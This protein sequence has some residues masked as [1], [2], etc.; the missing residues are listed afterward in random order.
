MKMKK[1]LRNFAKVMRLMTM[2][3]FLGMS[4]INMVYSGIVLNPKTNIDDVVHFYDPDC[5]FPAIEKINQS[6][7]IYY[8]SPTIIA[9]LV[10]G[11]YNHK[12]VFTLTIKGNLPDSDEYNIRPFVRINCGEEIIYN[13]ELSCSN[14]SSDMTNTTMLSCE[15]D[16]RVPENATVC[17]AY[18]R[19]FGNNRTWRDETNCY[20]RNSSCRCRIPNLSRVYSSPEREPLTFEEYINKC[21]LEISRRQTEMMREQTDISKRQAEIMKRQVDISQ[22]SNCMMILA[23]AIGVIGTIIG[24]ILG[25]IFSDFGNYKNTKRETIERIYEPLCREL[26]TLKDILSEDG[27]IKVF[28]DSYI[29]RRDHYR[30]LS[31]TSYKQEKLPGNTEWN[32]ILNNYLTAW[33]PP[34]LLIEIKGLYDDEELLK[35]Y[36]SIRPDTI[37]VDK[38]KEREE[39]KIKILEKISSLQKHLKEQM[40]LGI[41]SY[42]KDKVKK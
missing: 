42:I 3:S 20:D 2:M 21:Q 32:R 1:Y 15:G 18:A 5:E 25:F 36:D 24:V 29:K 16:F 33:I 34:N 11:S 31:D 26:D 41:M 8:S 40:D 23:A 14:K 10:K 13:R 39:A 7:D 30:R 35:N 27:L 6:L 9:E 22:Q 37:G 19:V 4:L 38:K 17:R 12:V 28:Y